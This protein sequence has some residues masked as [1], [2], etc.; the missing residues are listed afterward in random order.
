MG[1]S[2]SRK[3]SPQARQIYSLLK[4][5]GIRIGK[6]QASLFWEEVLQIAPCMAED[7]I[8][9]P[10]SWSKVASLIKNRDKKPPCEFL[11]ILAAIRQCIRPSKIGQTENNTAPGAPQLNEPKNQGPKSHLV[12]DLEALTQLIREIKS[13]YPPLPPY[14]LEEMKPCAPPVPPSPI[15]RQGFIKIPKEPSPAFPLTSQP[16][17]DK[18]PPPPLSRKSSSPS[19]SIDKTQTAQTFPVNIHP[20]RTK[21]LKWHPIQ[22]S[23][24]KELRQAVKEDGIHAPWTKSLLQSHIANLNTPQDWRDICR[25]ALPDP[26]FLEWEAYYRDECLQQVRQNQGREDD[27]PWGFKELFGQEDFSTGA[28]QAS[29]PTGYYDQVRLCATQAWNRLTPPS[30]SQDPAHSLLSLH[31]K[32]GESLSDFILRTKM[33]LERKISN[34][35]ARDLLLKT[36][37]WEGMTS[38]S[39][40]ACQGLREEHHDRWIVATREIGTPSNQVASI[41]QAFVAAIK[42]EKICLKCGETRHWKDEC[43]TTCHLRGRETQ[44]DLELARPPPPSRPLRAGPAATATALTSARRERRGGMS[45]AGEATTCDT[46]LPQAADPA[47]KSPAASGTPQAPAPAP[48]LAGS[49]GRD[50]APGPAPASSAPV[51]SEDSEKKVLATKVLGT[52]KWFNVRNGYGFI[53]RNDTKEDVFVHQTAI[54]KNNPRGRASSKSVLPSYCPQKT[55]P[56]NSRTVS[57]SQ[58]SSQN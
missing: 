49:P 8:Y 38:E 9:S 21:P 22:A 45:E 54:K 51:G 55:S 58:P 53:N 42:T 18:S 15:Q 2:T 6:R 5:H 40:L 52:V 12:S 46:T 1:N 34:P 28:Q 31:Q 35:T 27:T 10:D 17:R 37:V 32:P 26:M 33:S 3:C 48:P 23:D 43:P 47:P 24:L 30:G 57:N 19:K 39:R 50:A 29:Q 4:T 16:K 36:I 44:R 56:R 13:I 41:A 7:N 14:A 25:S 20:T 11:P